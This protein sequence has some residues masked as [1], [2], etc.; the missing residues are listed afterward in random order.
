MSPRAG[1][2]PERLV[3]LYPL[4]KVMEVVDKCHS[5]TLLVHNLHY[6]FDDI[7]NRIHSFCNEHNT[8]WVYVIFVVSIVN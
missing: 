5:K 4:N 1:E 3:S 8:T 6:V 7:S 2:S